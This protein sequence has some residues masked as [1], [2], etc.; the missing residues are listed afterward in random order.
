MGALLNKYDIW[1]DYDY[2]S[3]L[4]APRMENQKVLLEKKSDQTT[5]III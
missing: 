2:A 4:G 5:Q 3:V 1:H